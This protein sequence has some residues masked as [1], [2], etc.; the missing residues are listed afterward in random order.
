MK[1]M[2]Q[3]Y[4]KKRLTIFSKVFILGLIAVVT[5]FPF[6]W[7]IISSFKENSEIYGNA[8]AL[9]TVLNFKNYQEAWRGA[10]V[11]VSLFNSIFYCVVAIAVILLI[12]SMVSYV[13]A[14]VKPSKLMYAYF[15]LGIMIPLHAVIIPLNIIYKQMGILNTR[16]GIIIAFI[17]SNVSFSI[18][19]LTAFMKGI[20]GALEEAARIDGCGRVRMIFTIIVPIS[21]SALA[22]VGTLAFVNCWNDLLLSLAITTTADLRTLNLA[23]Y[24]LRAQ[25]VSDYGI[26]TAGITIM[27]IPALLIYMLFQEQIIKGMVSGAVKG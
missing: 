3:A 11:A 17:V 10:N 14:R 5:I 13:L 27:V 21:K 15:S 16:A 9:P 24:N 26:I 6:Y 2:S 7:V 25:Y 19:V 12:A 22:T 4:Y 23:V 18:F 1:K 20:P 8:F